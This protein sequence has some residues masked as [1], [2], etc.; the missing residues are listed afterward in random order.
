M[1]FLNITKG[2]TKEVFE[3]LFENGP[4]FPKEMFDKIHEKSVYRCL[5]RLEELGAAVRLTEID[6]DGF[7]AYIPESHQIY[8]LTPTQIGIYISEKGGGKSSI[9]A[10]TPQYKEIMELEEKIVELSQQ[11]K[12]KYGY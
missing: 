2:K 12:E 1:K 4:S 8:F 6:E 10:L 9:W 3:Y 5:K 11:A 7:F